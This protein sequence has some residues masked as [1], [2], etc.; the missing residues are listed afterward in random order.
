MT[1]NPTKKLNCNVKNYELELKKTL[2]FFKSRFKKFKS[3][4]IAVIPADSK[5]ALN[6]VEKQLGYKL[7]EDL[8]YFYEYCDGFSVTWD[9]IVENRLIEGSVN[10][11]LSCLLASLELGK[12][13]VLSLSGIN[14]KEADLSTNQ[15]KIFDTL[16]CSGNYVLIDF[17]NNET[18][19]LFTFGHNLNKINLTVK[20]Y[21]EYSVLFLG[22]NLWQQFFIDRSS[23]ISGYYTFY[24]NYETF[25]KNIV[26]DENKTRVN[27]ILEKI[28][29]ENSI[30]PST[31]FLEDLNDRIN[32]LKQFNEFGS[33]KNESNNPVSLNDLMKGQEAMKVSLSELVIGFYLQTNGLKL[34]WEIEDI[35]G[36][37][38]L[39]PFE[40]IFGG[41]NCPKLNLDWDKTNHYGDTICSGEEDEDYILVASKLRP[42]E[43]FEGDSGFVGFIVNDNKE[44]ELYYSHSRGELT[45]LPISFEKYLELS[46]RLLGMDGWQEYYVSREQARI[47]NSKLIDNIKSIFPDFQISEF[48]L[49]D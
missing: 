24:D 47:G 48:E 41:E 17:Q 12:G 14:S 27:K 20:Q 39:L 26:Q 34:E 9:A 29:N 5:S 37:I 25:F 28:D 43:L 15:L 2:K 13:R 45:K 30:T 46:I 18:L 38:S 19:Y 36:S 32:Q 35:H 7:S 22:L 23:D 42:V 31:K 1:S 16:D 49:T 6:K 10:I 8:R 40:E 11:R 4:G 44:L 21:L 33:L 3:S